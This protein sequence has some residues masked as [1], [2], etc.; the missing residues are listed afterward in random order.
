MTVVRRLSDL[1]GIDP[2]AGMPL[3]GWHNIQA[4]PGE[5]GEIEAGGGVACLT[6]HITAFS[7]SAARSVVRLS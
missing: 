6:N 3:V 1:G 2:A 4:M 7:D 5:A